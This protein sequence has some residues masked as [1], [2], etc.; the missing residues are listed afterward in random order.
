MIRVMVYKKKEGLRDVLVRPDK[1]SGLPAMLSRA[2][3]SEDVGMATAA[4]LESL[5]NKAE[6]RDSRVPS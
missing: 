1:R 6:Q 4:I 5:A 3:P 2:V